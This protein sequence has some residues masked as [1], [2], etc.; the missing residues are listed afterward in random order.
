MAVVLHHIWPEKVPGGFVGVDVFFVISGYLITRIIN[1]E[2]ETG[3]F[4]FARFYERRIRRLFPVL[5]TMLAAVIVAG[6]F[7]QLPSDYVSTFGASVGTLLFSSNVYFWRQLAEGYFAPDAK[8]NPL[9]HTWSL[10]VEEQFYV[11]F[12]VLLLALHRWFPAR[13]KSVLVVCA[14]VSLGAAALLIER[15]AVAVFFLSPF[16]AWELLAGSLLGLRA[17]PGLSGSASRGVLA[18]FGI[19]CIVLSVGLYT[20]EMR[21]PGWAAAVPVLGACAIIH[22]GEDCNATIVSR[23]LA[24]RPMVYVGL[25]S[26]SLY[27]WHWPVVVFGKLLQ[28]FVPNQG[29]SWILLIISLAVGSLSYHWIE[30]PSRVPRR[31][32]SILLASS[33]LALLTLAMAIPGIRSGG[34]PDRISPAVSAYETARQ[35]EIPFLPCDKAEWCRVGAAGVEPDTLF[36]GDSH[37]LVWGPGL[38]SALKK[39]E[40]AGYFVPHSGCPPL[41]DI[42]RI[43]RPECALSNARV[44]QFLSR[45]G[46]VRYVVMAARWEYYDKPRM[47]R[48][49]AEPSLS[50]GQKLLSV[51]LGAT[52]TEL[53][54]MKLGVLVIGQVPVYSLDVPYGLAYETWHQTELGEMS[55]EL[56]RALSPDVG[57][58]AKGAGAVFADPARWMCDPMCIR[59]VDG[60]SLYKDKD[61]LSIAGSLRYASAL[62][63]ALDRL[64]G[65]NIHPTSSPGSR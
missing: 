36:F 53:E 19:A 17:F 42:E 45:N 22:A 18:L 23:V 15:H 12:P 9:L 54:S 11:A 46:S 10:G 14:I 43:D 51:A 61:H 47:I 26:Y 33:G 4:T 41:F 24:Y 3:T 59:Q 44:R 52:I 65:S 58:I 62:G 48:A 30:K 29:G 35:E 28:G 6:W 21:F 63:A 7:L 25:I 2:I 64:R 50:A 38:D 16:R 57:A 34:F 39:R 40:L 60:V 56:H 5:F 20:P 13:I 37:M 55:L 31:Y 32:K 27:L 49:S 1:A 8:F